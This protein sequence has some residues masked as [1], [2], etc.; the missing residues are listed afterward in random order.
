MSASTVR[1]IAHV[2]WMFLP[3]PTPDNH[4]EARFDT[5]GDGSLMT[6]GMKLPDA[7]TRAKMLATGME[8]GMEANYARLAGMV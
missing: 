6:M 1:Q 3:D 7:D 4:L 5:A 8:H 2:E